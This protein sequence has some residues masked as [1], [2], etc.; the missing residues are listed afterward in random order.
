MLRTAA[1]V[2]VVAS[3]LAAGCGAAQSTGAPDMRTLAIGIT[4]SL[5]E[6][7]GPVRWTL[8]V[9][10]RRVWAGEAAS[11][12]VAVEVGIATDARTVQLAGEADGTARCASSFVQ[13]ELSR[14]LSQRSAVARLDVDLATDASGVVRLR[15]NHSGMSHADEVESH[16]GEA[17]P[18]GATDAELARFMGD[19]L[20]A[21]RRSG[22]LSALACVR[23]RVDQASAL[24]GD[25]VARTRSPQPIG[26]AAETRI[27]APSKNAQLRALASAAAQCPLHGHAP[28]LRFADRVE[29]DG[30]PRCG[31]RAPESRTRIDAELE[32]DARESAQRYPGPLPPI[33]RRA[34]EDTTEVTVERV[35]P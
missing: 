3:V 23:R 34:G 11:E 8:Y 13:V 18:A 32:G 28:A 26:L 21:A 14:T 10:R 20:L 5:P 12:P 2:A 33:P 7:I 4:S 15:S 19:L 24:L 1:R 9:D 27:E 6:S 35:A 17:P 16:P 22:D 31:V 25:R 29:V 30:P